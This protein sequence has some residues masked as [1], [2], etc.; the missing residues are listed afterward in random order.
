MSETKV[1]WHRWPDEKPKRD[2]VYLC[3]LLIKGKYLGL[4]IW[5]Y[6]EDN[7]T[8]WHM[9]ETEEKKII[10]WAEPPRPYQPK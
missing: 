2:N 3:T 7:L 5:P 4:Q 10:A 9:I 8:P 6:S 1:K